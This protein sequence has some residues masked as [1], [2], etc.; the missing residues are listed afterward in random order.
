MLGAMLNSIHNLRFYQK[1]MNN[2]R[3]AILQGKLATF[4]E[5]FYHKRGLTVPPLYE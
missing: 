1:L 2:L 3:N 5:E 4:V